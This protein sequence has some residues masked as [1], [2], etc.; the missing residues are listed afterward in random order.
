[1]SVSFDFCGNRDRYAQCLLCLFR[2][3]PQMQFLDKVCLHF[4]VP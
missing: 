3:I 1:M 4:V 2:E